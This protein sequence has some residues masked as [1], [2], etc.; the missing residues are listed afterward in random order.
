MKYALEQKAAK[1]Q[2]PGV[3]DGQTCRY[4]CAI[5]SLAVLICWLYRRKPAKNTV[6]KQYTKSTVLLALCYKDCVK[7]VRIALCY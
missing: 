1:N 3:R 5:F 4:I 7:T 2:V 6:L